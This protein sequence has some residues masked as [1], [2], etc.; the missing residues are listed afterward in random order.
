[1]NCENKN[2]LLNLY[3]SEGSEQELNETREHVANC[4]DCR[5]YIASVKGTMNILDKLENEAPSANVFDNILAEVSES[6]RK[7]AV[8]KSG[9]QLTSIL[10]IAFGEIFLFALIYFLKIQITLMPLWSTVQNNWLVKS[11]GSS[12]IAVVIVLIAGAFITLSF[13]PILLFESN[14]K[15]NFN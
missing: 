13:A 11:L 3:F 14:S 4:E 10:Q 12:G 5:E 6:V 9:I 15:K 2:H 8:R 1:M 7:P